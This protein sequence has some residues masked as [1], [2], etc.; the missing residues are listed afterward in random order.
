MTAACGFDAQPLQK[1]AATFGQHERHRHLFADDEPE[2][3]ERPQ[4]VDELERRRRKQLQDR[5]RRGR[6]AR[7]RSFE[8]VLQLLESLQV[9]GHF[10]GAGDFAIEAALLFVSRM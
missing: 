2:M 4:C 7:S 5:R 10:V 9:L 8:P 1:P 3:F 6:P